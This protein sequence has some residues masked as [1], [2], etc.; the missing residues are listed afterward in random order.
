[1]RHE[2]RF[3]FCACLLLAVSATS[4]HA[5]Q[6]TRQETTPGKLSDTGR[7][8]LGLAYSYFEAGNIVTAFDRIMIAAASDPQSPE[9]QALLGMIEDRRGNQA[10]A[11]DAYNRAL[12]LAP[13][14]GNVLN[15]YGAWLCEHGSTTQAD[16]YFQK[17][18]LDS[19]SRTPRNALV[20]AGRCAFKAN[21]HAKAEQYLRRALELSSEDASALLLL[22]E[23]K[24]AQGQFFEARAFLQRREALGPMGPAAYELAAKI[25]TGAGDARSAQR[26][27]ALLLEKY[28]DH[29]SPT[30]EGAGRQ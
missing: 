15:A 8:N 28:P 4:A 9:V 24:H 14:N 25:E 30:G 26:Y 6:E 21:E 22:A 20:N 23:V 11:T 12:S 7:V 18:L 13:D 3:M 29:Q 17:A 19:A 16:I 5:K 2:L 10:L 27:R 1:M